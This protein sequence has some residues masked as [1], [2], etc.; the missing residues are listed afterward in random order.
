MLLIPLVLALSGS[1]GP[2][3][4]DRAAPEPDYR[5]R[6]AAVFQ[7]LGNRALIVPSQAAFALD[8]QVGFQ[9]ATDFQYLTGID[10]LVGAVLVQDG[11]AREAILF[12]QP[13]NPL[14]KRPFPSADPSAATRLGLTFV[15]PIDSLEP[16]LRRKLPT[17]TGIVVSRTDPR[18]AVA[19]PAPIANGVARWTAYLATLGKV[20]RVESSV[21]VVL[22]LREIKDP[23]EIAILER[24]G[25]MSGRAMLAGIRGLRPDR[26]Q[27]QAQ[28]EVVSSCVADGGRH[29]FWPW[30]MSGPHA[31]FTDLFDSFVDYEGHERVM[32]AGELVRVDVGC[33]ADHYMGDV[34]RT[35]PVSGRY[36]PGQREAWDLFIA[37]YRAGLAGFKDGARTADIYRLML[38]RVRNDAP[39]LKT[40]L[41]RKAAAVLLG[42]HGTDPWEIHGVG[43]DDAEGQPEVLRAGM[44]VA[45]ELMFEVL[46]QGFYLED[47]VLVTK[48]GQRLLTPGLPYTAREIEAV[49]AERNGRR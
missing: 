47:M 12:L 23:G 16:W 40:T 37:G 33:Q 35:A 34:G 31:V 17:W 1:T 15:W 22:P 49:M 24:V 48:D 9:Q 19:G 44:T 4:A 45:Y 46:G 8:D 7:R 41:G 26:P 29:S 36:D 39:A 2:E 3:P 32:R 27:R 21:S 18:G 42:P 6:R 10:H 20:P 43:L 13:P 25:R 14:V 11:P 5:A 38:D 30:T 28:L